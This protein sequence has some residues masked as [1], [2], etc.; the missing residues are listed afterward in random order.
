MVRLLGAHAASDPLADDREKVL[1]VFL[2]ES[3]QS[4]S[5]RFEV[6]PDAAVALTKNNTVSWLAGCLDG[7]MAGWLADWRAACFSFCSDATKSACR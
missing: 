1:R 5:K 7:W 4:A 2:C 6:F 3:H